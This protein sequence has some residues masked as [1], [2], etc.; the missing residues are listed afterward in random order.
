VSRPRKW[1]LVSVP[2][3]ARDKD[4]LGLCS[5]ANREIQID[6]DQ[7]RKQWI[8]ALVHECLHAAYPG[9]D[10]FFEATPFEEMLIKRMEK[11]LARVLLEVGWVPPKKE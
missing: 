5:L 1:K 7:P 2:F 11:P 4:A 9:G 8:V 6:P 3:L 10:D